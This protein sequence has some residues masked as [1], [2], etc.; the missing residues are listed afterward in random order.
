MNPGLIV[1]DEATSMLDPQ[2]K[3]EILAIIKR[4]NREQHKTILSITHDM[5]EITAADKVLVLDEGKIVFS[6]SPV[7]LVNKEEILAAAKMRLPFAADFATEFNK[8]KNKIKIPLT[9]DLLAEELWQS[10][11]KK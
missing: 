11:L 1:F 9:L 3:A 2:G 7:E 8:G 10:S 5:E 6:G 4:L